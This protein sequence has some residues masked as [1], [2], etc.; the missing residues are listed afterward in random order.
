MTTM[1]LAEKTPRER[2]IEIMQRD[3]LSVEDVAGMVKGSPD[4]VRS[5][6]KPETSK[7]HRTPS[8]TVLRILDLACGALIV[9]DVIEAARA[10]GL[11]IGAV[12]E[13]AIGARTIL[14]G[15][16]YAARRSGDD[17]LARVLA[18]ETVSI[19]F[20][21]VRAIIAKHWTM[22][23]I[24]HRQKTVLLASPSKIGTSTDP[25]GAAS[26]RLDTE[27]DD[28][29]ERRNVVRHRVDVSRL[30]ELRVERARLEARLLDHLSPREREGIEMELLLNEKAMGSLDNLDDPTPS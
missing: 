17:P 25:D 20:G 18:G 7:S 3:N 14:A 15:G 16:L 2:L 21:P 27:I 12:K 5:W 22:V 19:E 30:N 13:K 29:R 6:L 1:D 4:T 9:A 26:H 23:P 24:S 11:G 10:L 8:E 28:W